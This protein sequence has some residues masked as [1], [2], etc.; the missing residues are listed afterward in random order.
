MV[1]ALPDPALPKLIAFFCLFLLLSPINHSPVL[2]PGERGLRE[3]EVVVLAEL[4]WAGPGP[5][6]FFGIA[7][8]EVPAASETCGGVRRDPNYVCLPRLWARPRMFVRTSACG[9]E[10]PLKAHS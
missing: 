9:F 7:P 2:G 5:L 6:H 8:E 3:R 10:R 1:T 4:G